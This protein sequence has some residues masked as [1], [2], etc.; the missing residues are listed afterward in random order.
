MVLPRA[1]PVE[2]KLYVGVLCPKCEEYMMWAQD[3][4]YCYNDGC[5]E[6]EKKYHHP[7]VTLKEKRC[8]S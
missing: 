5:T 1:M 4:I 2:A 6:V 3:G 8:T 7:T